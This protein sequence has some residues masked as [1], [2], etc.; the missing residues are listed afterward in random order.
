MPPLLALETSG[1]SLGVALRAESGLLFEENVVAGA[2]HGKALAPL[3]LKALSSSDLKPADLGAV[4]VS[5]GPGSW[6]G[7]RIGLSAAKALAWGAN[8]ALLGVPS[9]E[10]L[11]LDAARLAP[12]H[13]RLLL[14]DARSE[15]FF[16][17]LFGPERGQTANPDTSGDRQPISKLPVSL[18]RLPA[19]G[20]SPRWEIGVS[21]RW[22]GE[23]VLRLPAVIE[24]VEQE[25]QKHGNVPLAVCG[26]QACL[27]AVSKAAGKNRWRVLDGCRH[28]TAGSVAE[29]GWQRLM[30]GEGLRTPAE[31]HKLTPLYLRASDPELKLARK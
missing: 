21:P 8:L 19:G 20:V 25:M 15:G 16:L 30:R 4:A 28:V 14:R 2:A 17:A 31:I 23:C 12:G 6:T 27:Q 5:L 10:A 1:A 24:A 9:F 11:A 18:G 13:A 3:I 7:L 22:I 26:D 29:C